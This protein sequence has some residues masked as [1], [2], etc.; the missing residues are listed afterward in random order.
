MPTYVYK[1]RVCGHEFEKLT[2]IAEKDQVECI[3]C[4]QSVKRM[5]T[6]FNIGA[7]KTP[8]AAGGS[9]CFDTAKGSDCPHK[10]GGG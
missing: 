7:G 3:K 5:L 2:S 8:P 1:C 4:G 9:G 10:S 6:S